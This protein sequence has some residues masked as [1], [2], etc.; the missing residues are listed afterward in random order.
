MLKEYPNDLLIVYTMAE[1]E[2]AEKNYEIAEN[3][4]KRCLNI[5]PDNLNCKLGLAD[6]WLEEGKLEKSKEV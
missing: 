6:V 5:S 1:I 2:W 4:Y 3:L